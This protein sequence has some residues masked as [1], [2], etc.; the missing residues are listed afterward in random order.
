MQVLRNQPVY[1][2]VKMFST[3]KLFPNISILSPIKSQYDYCRIEKSRIL[4]TRTRRTFPEWEKELLFGHG[5]RAI[6]DPR[7]K[8]NRM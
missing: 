2:G 1:G 6:D 8:E 5:L 4:R 7:A 3:P